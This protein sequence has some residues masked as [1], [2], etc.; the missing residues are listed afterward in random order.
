[1]P[2]DAAA[3]DAADDAAAADGG[4]DAATDAGIPEDGFDRHPWVDLLPEVFDPEAFAHASFAALDPDFP[5]ER[6]ATQLISVRVDEAGSLAGWEALVAARS[7]R[8]VQ[9]IPGVAVVF[10]ELAEPATTAAGLQEELDAFASDANVTWA[11]PEVAGVV[12]ALPPGV[13]PSQREPVDAQL[14]VGMHRVWDLQ[15]HTRPLLRG[16][17]MADGPGVVVI[18]TFDNTLP[19]AELFEGQFTIGGPA[20]SPGPLDWHG[21]GVLS[22]MMPRWDLSGRHP[23]R[24]DAIAGPVTFPH[25][26]T[27][28]GGGGAVFAAV[29]RTLLHAQQSP[30]PLVVQ[31][32]MHTGCFYERCFQNTRQRGLALAHALQQTGLASRLL[33]VVVAGNDVSSIPPN[34]RSA[35][36]Q[37]VVGAAPIDNKLMV[38]A[39]IHEPAP[40]PPDASGRL[41]PVFAYCSD[42]FSY[43]GGHVSA[44]G[45]D[46]PSYDN[47]GT[48]MTPRGT[49]FAAPQVSG[50]ATR[51]WQLAPSLTPAEVAAR[52]QATARSPRLLS[53]AS[54]AMCASRSPAPVLDA[55]QAVL[56][57]DLHDANAPLRRE[58]LDVNDDGRFGRDD[59]VEFLDHFA[60]PAVR[61]Q[62]LFDRFDL[63]GDGRL[64]P[65]SVAAFD[66]DG[67]FAPAGDP[68]DY[69]LVRAE[70]TNDRRRTFEVRLD[71]REVS[72]LD[73]LCYYAYS[74]L[75]EASDAAARNTLL[76]A[77][78]SDFGLTCPDIRP[79]I[80]APVDVCPLGTFYGERFAI[81]VALEGPAAF[82]VFATMT[83]TGDGAIDPSVPSP[84]VASPFPVSSRENPKR[85]VE[86]DPFMVMFGSV[87]PGG[88]LLVRVELEQETS[89]GV[90]RLIASDAVTI[91]ARPESECNPPLTPPPP[92]PPSGSRGW[93]S[94]STWQNSMTSP[95]GSSSESGSGHSWVSGPGDNWAFVS[96]TVSHRVSVVGPTLNQSTGTTLTIVRYSGGQRSESVWSRSSSNGVIVSESG[97]TTRTRPCSGTCAF[98]PAPPDD[99]PQ[100]TGSGHLLAYDGPTYGFSIFDTLPDGSTVRN[101]RAVS[102]VGCRGES[103]GPTCRCDPPRVRPVC[104]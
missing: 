2:G 60:D 65:E 16:G 5:E 64:G 99:P 85:L 11:L 23:S 35:E 17:V 32:S 103:P 68:V 95:A 69:D 91:Q 36:W 34:R 86:L 100:C 50:V 46:I 10:V 61:G 48:Y 54:H 29:I 30:T 25:R 21:F 27:L 19:R 63:N 12:A 41:R 24:V 13:T 57:A 51:L 77:T 71:E 84:A 31:Q 14:A 70:F 66:L 7:A 78:Y 22:V 26:V 39:I 43:P 72:D 88:S 4:A 97:P 52:V 45:R 98:P 76:Y 42:L 94:T 15:D 80:E 3:P 40:S 74:D 53:E 75:F 59:L 96:S 92:P 67:P 38:E 79:R 55:H 104:P 18:D 93:H 9:S 62:P 73:V 8:V 28:E 47:A 101:S 56:A 58:L 82:P 83:A 87:R 37:S 1:M 20:W 90:R 89:S 81:G 102:C 44:P 6:I 49:S 33:Y